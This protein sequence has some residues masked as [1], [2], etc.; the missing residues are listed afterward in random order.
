MKKVYK[1][2]IKEGA[3]VIMSRILEYPIDQVDS[4]MDGKICRI[5]LDYPIDKNIKKGYLDDY[6]EDKL[7]QIEI[8]GIIEKEFL[9]VQSLLE[10][11]DEFVFV[12]V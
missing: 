2:K 1:Y 9:I 4:R 3:S 8:Y 5:T 12:N 10:D 11:L 7:W 6:K